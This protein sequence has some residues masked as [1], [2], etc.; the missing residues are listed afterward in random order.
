M[1]AHSARAWLLDEAQGR[2]RG[3]QALRRASRPTRRRS[4]KFGIDTANMFGFWDWVG[5]RYSLWSRDRPAHRAA[6]IGMDNFEEMLAGGARDGR[7][8]PHRAARAEP[9]GD[10]RA[11]RR[12]V[13]ELL[14]RARRT[15][16]C[17]TTSTCTASPPTS[18]RATW[19]ATASASTARAS[20]S[21][22]TRP[23]P[24]VW[25]EPGTNG[26]HAFYQLIH[27]GTRLV[28]CD[29][30]APVET[31]NPLGEH[32]AILLANFFA[33][34]EALMKG[35]TADEARAELE[36]AEAAAGDAS[37]S[38]CRTRRSPA[39]A[40]R[41]RSCSRSS[42]RA[43]SAC[44][45]RC[46]S[47]RSSRRASSGTSTASTSGAWS[48]ASSSRQDPARARRRR[49]SDDARRVHERPHQPLQ[50]SP[51]KSLRL[52]GRGTGT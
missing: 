47:T 3:R 31:H 26:Q 4:Q 46:T 9:A 15:R 25:G 51:S 27:Q 13:L 39:T 36:G 50:S 5:G 19:R 8:L 45:S 11:A 35:K 7:A 42:R 1:N 29:F 30:L 20:R 38:S 24:I 37:K 34:T 44:S 33:Q 6:S 2:K 18:S 14:R 17:R 49:R 22:T 41:T 10:P 23:G 52:S 48:S 21:P 16:S 12:L 40:R 43:R 28:P 32:H